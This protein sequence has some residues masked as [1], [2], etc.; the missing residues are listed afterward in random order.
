MRSLVVYTHYNVRKPNCVTELL[1]ISCI[2][3][4]YWPGQGAVSTCMSETACTDPGH[5]RNKRI[6]GAHS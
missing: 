4:N 2:L 5:A 6:S 3:P 1:Q